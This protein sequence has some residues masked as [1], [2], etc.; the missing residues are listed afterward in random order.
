[1]RMASSRIG[2]NL[3]TGNIG[4]EIHSGESTTM[5][6]TEDTI[7]SKADEVEIAPER[8]E[9]DATQTEQEVVVYKRG[10]AVRYVH[11]NGKFEAA[12]ILQVHA[13]EDEGRPYFSMRLS[14]GQEKQTENERLQPLASY[15]K[16]TLKGGKHGS[17]NAPNENAFKKSH[18]EKGS[19]SRHRR[20]T[21]KRNKILE[22][23][24]RRSQHAKISWNGNEVAQFMSKIVDNV[25]N[26]GKNDVVEAHLDYERSLL[27]ASFLSFLAKVTTPLLPKFENIEYEIGFL[28]ALES[29]IQ[30]LANSTESCNI[31]SNF[32][33]TL[34]ILTLLVNKCVDEKRL[35]S[36]QDNI[37]SSV[38]K[39]FQYQGDTVNDIFSWKLLMKLNLDLLVEFKVIKRENENINALKKSLIPFE[40]FFDANVSA[41]SNSHL[42]IICHHANHICNVL[43]GFKDKE[44]LIQNDKRG[45]YFFG[46]YLQLLKYL[47]PDVII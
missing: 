45:E 13:D 25:A 19:G 39:M 22:M 2:N 11:K 9:L 35:S 14:S 21:S 26:H 46:L 38:E 36:M 17:P 1:M 28:D 7:S 20:Q 12:V 41:F 37:L 5:P 15:V 6:L 43:A 44:N 23:N 47:S 30:E 27:V 42:H 8:S 3:S 31:T 4:G 40:S 34:Y 16:K 29:I 10:D 24:K 18:R 32:I 33:S